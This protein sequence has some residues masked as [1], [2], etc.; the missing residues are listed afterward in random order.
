MFVRMRAMLHRLFW[1]LQQ[2]ASFIRVL[3]LNVSQNLDIQNT[4]THPLKS[5]TIMRF[6][7][8]DECKVNLSLKVSR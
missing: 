3:G 4:Y 2:A 7:W 8:L 5:Q 1:F 6:S